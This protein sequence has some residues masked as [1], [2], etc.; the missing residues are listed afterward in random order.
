MVSAKARLADRAEVTSS[1][2]RPSSLNQFLSCFPVA[3]TGG[4]LGAALSQRRR[5]EEAEALRTARGRCTKLREEARRSAAASSSPSSQA[6]LAH[7][8]KAEQH[9]AA[10][11][12]WLLQDVQ[13][14]ARDGSHDRLEAESVAELMGDCGPI[15]EEDED[16]FVKMF[17]TLDDERLLV[18]ISCSVL[19]SSFF[20]PGH[21]YLSSQRLCFYSLV[22]GIE[23][24]LAVHHSNLKNILL[25]SDSGSG[26]ASFGSSGLRV[27]A[28]MGEAVSFADQN[29][30]RLE[31]R[32]F[33][34][35]ALGHLHKWSVYYT[36]VGLFDAHRALTARSLSCDSSPAKS[37]SR[38]AARTGSLNFLTPQ[39]LEAKAVVWQLERR[40]TIFSLRWF[41]PW[42][43]H[44]AQKKCK[45]MTL[46]GR[47]EP[48]P[49][50]PSSLS[51]SV[52]ATSETPP[53]SQVQLL[54]TSRPCSWQ[55]ITGEDTDED[56]WQYA[57]DFFVR[58][59]LWS[60][61]LRCWSQVRRRRWKPQ[62]SGPAPD[63]DEE[64]D[65]EKVF[66]NMPTMILTQ[67]G[68][69]KQVTLLE[70]DIGE[71]P[72]AALA[73]RLLQDDWQA[74][75]SLMG[76]YFEEAGAWD[77]E[78]GPWAVGGAAAQ[79]KGKVRSV[80]MRVPVPP[81]PMCPKET[82]CASTWHVVVDSTR[83]LLESVNMSLDVPYGDCFNVVACDTFTVNKETNRM[84]MVRTCGVDWVKSTW[85]KSMVEANVPPEVTK[86]GE[87]VANVVR[88]YMASP[89]P[90]A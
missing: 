89:P 69:A 16:S 23:T 17:P 70:V 30:Y 78:V 88:R 21:L 57:V 29:L 58:N 71:V 90:L 66:L 5:R 9:L 6:P 60:R 63:A 31:L 2:S 42:L 65:L 7:L 75:G 13:S 47:Y 76:M 49:D 53:I 74:Q 46:G 15:S 18:K 22:L 72:L 85:M 24:S 73:E 51:E 45:W 54:G 35:K 61:S 27:R 64:E 4:G 56:G 79:V 33:D 19:A 8:R 32:I 26:A 36:G 28:C 20:Y 80:D 84:Q 87:R 50:L 11:E 1:S 83:V 81:A 77:V 86:A 44:D 38:R 3:C 59:T 37:P 62:C 10:V 68:V 34:H 39:D 43:P 25:I 41:A 12:R 14:L 52:V 82:R 67:K 48:H 55:L 40:P